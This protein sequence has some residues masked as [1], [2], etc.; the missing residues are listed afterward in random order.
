MHYRTVHEDLIA[1]FPELGE[2]YRRLF[3]DWDNFQGDPP[4]Q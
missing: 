1:A 2:P 3:D 4:G